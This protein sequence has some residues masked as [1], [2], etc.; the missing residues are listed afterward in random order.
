MHVGGANNYG[1][2]SMGI[3]VKSVRLGTTAGQFSFETGC[4]VYGGIFQMINF[5][6][7]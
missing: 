1:Y 2:M 4:F 7:S 5:V 3:A 6:L